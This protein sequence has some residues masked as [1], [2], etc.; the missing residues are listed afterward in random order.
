MF[1]V[2]FGAN[3]W[4][5]GFASQIFSVLSFCVPF[6]AHRRFSTI[7]IGCLWGPCF[8]LLQPPCDIL[9]SIY[10][11]LLSLCGLLAAIY[12]NLF[13]AFLVDSPERICPAAVE[14]PFE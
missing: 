7:H 8:N 10:L 2:S 3:F 1:C 12:L 6:Q 4:L 13:V 9:A 11:T 14:P 5:S